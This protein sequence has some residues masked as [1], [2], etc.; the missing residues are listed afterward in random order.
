MRSTAASRRWT[1]IARTGPCRKY[2]RP[3]AHDLRRYLDACFITRGMS[4]RTRQRALPDECQKGRATS[5]CCAVEGRA[6]TVA[7]KQPSWSVVPR[8]GP[9][10]S[11]LGLR[12]PVRATHSAGCHQRRARGIC[13][14][15][16]ELPSCRS[17]S[18]GEIERIACSNHLLAARSDG[19]SAHLLHEAVRQR[20][21]SM[22]IQTSSPCASRGPF[23]GRRATRG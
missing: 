12:V 3:A 7:I 15:D 16:S 17:V 11:I 18:S 2:H 19:E 13:G 22:R 8:T 20:L 10:H 4:L 21:H 6:A 14:G 5:S 23:V 1:R 9:R